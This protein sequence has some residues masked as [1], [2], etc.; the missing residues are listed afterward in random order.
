MRSKDPLDKKATGLLKWGVKSGKEIEKWFDGVRFLEEQYVINKRRE[1][2]PLG[3][4][5]FFVLFPLL[6]KMTKVIR[7]DFE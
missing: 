6:P 5:I 7:L 4:R 3:N 2:F 1:V